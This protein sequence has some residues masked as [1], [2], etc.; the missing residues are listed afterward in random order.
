MRVRIEAPT[1]DDLAVAESCTSQPT[2]P[3]TR[4]DSQLGLVELRLAMDI[5]HWD[6]V[7]T[8][9]DWT[10]KPGME[11]SR[12]CPEEFIR[13]VKDGTLGYGLVA[14]FKTRSLIRR[15]LLDYPSVNPAVRI[16]VKQ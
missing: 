8:Q 4:R 15:Q 14:G 12:S 3:T 1:E 16:F 7:I 6:V 13:R 2:S 9:P 11:H 5:L 10:S